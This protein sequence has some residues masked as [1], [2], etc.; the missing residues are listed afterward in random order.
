MLCISL[1]Y[2][3]GAGPIIAPNLLE[4]EAERGQVKLGSKNARAELTVWV[5][6]L[7][8]RPLRGPQR[9]ARARGDHQAHADPTPRGERRPHRLLQTPYD[10]ALIFPF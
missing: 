6:S 8:W 9:E 5:Q 10:A 2:S 3:H 7:C 4:A 1:Q